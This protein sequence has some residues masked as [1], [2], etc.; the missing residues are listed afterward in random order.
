MFFYGFTEHQ[1]V[2]G[3]CSRRTSVPGPEFLVQQVHGSDVP[4][5]FLRNSTRLWDFDESEPKSA[6]APLREAHSNDQPEA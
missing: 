5:S 4:D 2:G 3:H 1:K 6:G